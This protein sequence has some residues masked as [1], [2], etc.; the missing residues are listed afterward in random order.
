MPSPSSSLSG[1][2][3]PAPARPAAAYGLLVFTML[4][5]SGNVVASKWAVGAVSPGALTCLRWAVVCLVLAVPA[6][7]RLA[8]ERD[9]LGARWRYVLLMG[10]LG[11]TGFASLFYAA[12]HD[13][14]GVNI[15]L[16]QGAIPVLVLVLNYLVHRTPVSG[17]QALGVAVTLAGV[18]V[19]ASHGDW[20]VLATLSLNRG[21]ALMLAACLLYAGYTVALPGRPRVS[22]LAFFSAMALAAFLT[23]LPG[24]AVEWAAGTLAMPGLDGWALVA[25][26]ALGPSLAAQ[27]SYLRGVALIGPNRAG[28]FVNL[29]PIF[30]ALLSVLLVGEAFRWDHALAL[31]LVLGGI[32][33]AERFGGPG[34]A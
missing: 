21:D 17:L 7:R 11:Y 3:G 19:A 28:V 1:R 13:T 30:G 29:V 26:V 10:G 23:A 2:A 5:W 6:R 25:F 24:V 22:G 14:T 9:R 18:A 15:A 27:L 16:F 12:G 20:R 34:A 4:M 33:V 8:A 32:V 31:V